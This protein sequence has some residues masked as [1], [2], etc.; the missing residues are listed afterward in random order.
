MPRSCVKISD[1]AFEIPRSA[2][3]YCIFSR[4]SLLIA[5]HTRSAFSDVL[6]VAGLLECGSLLTDSQP[7]LKHLC[8]TFTCASLI[9]SSLKCFWIHRGMFK[10]NAKFDADFLPSSLSHFEWEDHTVH[11]LIQWHQ[12]P[13]ITS[14]VKLSLFTHSHSSPL[15]LAARLHWHHAN[16]SYY[17]NDGWTFAEQT[18]CVEKPGISFWMTSLFSFW[19]PRCQHWLQHPEN[20]HKSDAKTTA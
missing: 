16:C 6:L 8:H 20:H 17:V 7:S 12:S 1:T 15:S 14:T 9:A 4:W 19:G 10:L 5:A 13:Q 2:S 18:S 3:S 11:M